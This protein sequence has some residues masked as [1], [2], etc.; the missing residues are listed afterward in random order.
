MISKGEL[1]ELYFKKENIDNFDRYPF[2]LPFFKTT[3]KLKFHPHNN[4]LFFHEIN[5]DKN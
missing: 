2:N 4:Y 1:I 5:F 3:D